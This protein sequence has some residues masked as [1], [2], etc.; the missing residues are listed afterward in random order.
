MLTKGGFARYYGGCALLNQLTDEDASP[1]NPIFVILSVVFQISW[2]IFK[3]IL[4]LIH[5]IEYTIRLTNMF[6]EN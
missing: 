5:Y 1:V 3:V 6:L 2:M 4:F